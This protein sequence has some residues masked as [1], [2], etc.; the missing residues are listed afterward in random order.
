MQLTFHRCLGELTVA[1][2][3][4][5]PHFLSFS[6]FSSVAAEAL[7]LPENCAED[8]VRRHV[9]ELRSLA[10]AS[11]AKD[12]E[13]RCLSEELSAFKA[14]AANSLA[15]YCEREQNLIS[16]L[17]AL[18]VVNADL[19]S[20]FAAACGCAKSKVSAL[21]SIPPR[22]DTAAGIDS[23]PEWPIP[24]VSDTL[25]RDA[26]LIVSSAAAV[27]RS[28]AV[29]TLRQTRK[30]TQLSAFPPTPQPPLSVSVPTHV[31]DLQ[32]RLPQLSFFFGHTRVAG[33]PQPPI[34]HLQALPPLFALRPRR[35][36]IFS[37]SFKHLRIPRA[38]P[39]MLHLE[40]LPT[41]CELHPHA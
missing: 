23:A 10:R 22:S 12:V 2:S 40:A 4:S 26:L 28:R 17:A 35:P 41:V 33:S 29:P 8:L 5:P 11:A 25:P 24:I 9:S 6:P 31:V 19:Q 38:D 20:L 37:F 34:L 14:S 21:L 1:G 3:T 36:P 27:T 7:E 39:P 30:V 16:R 13:L 32:Q 15:R 18:E